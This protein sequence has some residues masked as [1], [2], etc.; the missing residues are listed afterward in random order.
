MSS[1]LKGQWRKNQRR[2]VRL[3]L[4][5]RRRASSVQAEKKRKRRK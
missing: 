1:I 4:R 5:A 2:S 3:Q